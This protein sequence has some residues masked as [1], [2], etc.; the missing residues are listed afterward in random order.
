MIIGLTFYSGKT[1][2]TFKNAFKSVNA[3]KLCFLELMNWKGG[4]K[5]TFAVQDRF[6]Y[7]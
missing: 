3:Y 6:H 2:Q 5:V 7:I 1:I 4:F